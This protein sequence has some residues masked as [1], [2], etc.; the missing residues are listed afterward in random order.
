MSESPTIYDTLPEIELVYSLHRQEIHQ[1]TLQRGHDT[2]SLVQNF[3]I[4]ETCSLEVTATAS[5]AT[6]VVAGYVY[7][8]TVRDVTSYAPM[9]FRGKAGKVIMSMA[10]I[11]QNSSRIL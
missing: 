8:A 11:G 3:I 9:T 7:D 10:M 5:V 1:R 2:G 4:D 6:C